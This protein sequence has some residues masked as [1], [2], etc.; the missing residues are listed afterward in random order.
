MD[1]RDKLD[2]IE[3]SP[4]YRDISYY[5]ETSSDIIDLGDLFRNLIKE[6]KAMAVVMVIG[7]IGAIAIALYLPKEYLIES[8]LRVPSTEELGNLT[9]QSIVE[10][11]SDTALRRVVDQLLS[12]DVILESF[13][14]S[15]WMNWYSENS[16]L[17]ASQISKNIRDKLSIVVVRHDYYELANTEKAPFK[18][19]NVSLRSSQPE[20]A[21][22]Y[23]LV[24][25][26]NAHGEA[27]ANLSTEISRTK[28]TRVSKIQ[29]Q[30][31]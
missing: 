9:E 26:K 21:A 2:T 28:N 23:V 1:N 15:K 7:V 27:V 3:G 11:N 25:V 5:K 20:L 18:V 31:Q 24:L 4:R 22:K 16:S 19:I 29:E 13:E 6:W 12:P 14:S 8:M 17:N 10:I 30:L